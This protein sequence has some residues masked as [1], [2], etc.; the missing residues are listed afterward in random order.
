VWQTLALWLA[1]ASADGITGTAYCRH[2]VAQSKPV[3]KMSHLRRRNAWLFWRNVPPAYGMGGRWVGIL[4]V[5]ASKCSTKCCG[6]L[7]GVGV[8]GCDLWWRVVGVGWR[9][10]AQ[11]GGL[12]AFTRYPMPHCYP[13]CHCVQPHV[14]V[15]PC[16]AHH[17]A[18]FCP[19]IGFCP[20]RYL[21][22]AVGVCLLLQP[23]IV[24]ASGSVVLVVT[25]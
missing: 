11:A 3:A 1:Y 18:R 16:C 2:D 5:V 20:A 13:T 8:T 9:R 10:A 25:V 19:L 24:P 14:S 23:G 21:P 22:H 12:V 7:F 4:H 17:T 6:I 15:P